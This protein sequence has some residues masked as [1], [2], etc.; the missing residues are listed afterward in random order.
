MK[1]EEIKR[2]HLSKEFYIEFRDMRRG[3]IRNLY[4]DEVERIEDQA[5][6]VL[7]FLALRCNRKVKGEDLIDF[8]WDKP[9]KE[10]SHPA[11]RIGELKIQIQNKINNV[12]RHEF[13]DCDICQKGNPSY[14]YLS[15]KRGEKGHLLS[16]DPEYIEYGGVGRQE[17]SFNEKLNDIFPC[18]NYIDRPEIMM[19]LKEAFENRADRRRF[20]FLSGVGGIGKSELARKFAQKSKGSM[21]RAVVELEYRETDKPFDDA[22]MRCDSQIIAEF[23]SIPKDKRQEAK[24][25]LLLSADESIL[26]LVHNFDQ[27]DFEFLNRLK[28]RTGSARILF[29]T[30]LGIDSGIEDYGQVVSFDS[31]LD[32]QIAFAVKV[33][34]EYAKI[35][36]PADNLVRSIVSHIGG[37]TMMA[38]ILGRQVKRYHGSLKKVLSELE[39][40]VR[41]AL[42][43]GGEVFIAKDYNPVLP[44]QEEATPYNILKVIFCDVLKR[45]FTER[46]R[47]I[48][49]AILIEGSNDIYKA[50]ACWLAEMVGDLKD[51]RRC[52]EAQSAIN[53]LLDMGFIQKDRDRLALHP[54]IA[55]LVTDPELSEDGTIIAELSIDFIFHLL[56]NR[57]V[58]EGEKSS[59][60]IK[61]I[62]TEVWRWLSHISTIR[63]Y[64]FTNTSPRNLGWYAFMRD[65]DGDIALEHFL[66]R[67]KGKQPT[68]GEREA[69]E[70]E[71]SFYFKKTTYILNAI[72]YNHSNLGDEHVITAKEV[73]DMFLKLFAPKRYGIYFVI[74]YTN[75]RSLWLYD[76]YE[77]KEWCLINCSEQLL[78]EFRYYQ[79]NVSRRPQ[80]GV[81]VSA[82][83]VGFVADHCP[84]L[85]FVPSHIFDVPVI[86]ILRMIVHH[87]SLEILCLPATIEHLPRF[88]LSYGISLKAC[89]FLGTTCQI[90][91]KSFYF[92]PGLNYVCLPSK[93]SYIDIAND[94]FSWCRKLKEFVVANGT[95]FVIDC[96]T[97]RLYT[98]TLNSLS[99]ENLQY[100]QIGENG[101]LLRY[102]MNDISAL[103]GSPSLASPNPNV[104]LDETKTTPLDWHKFASDYFRE[105]KRL[106]KGIPTTIDLE[107]GTDC[108]VGPTGESLVAAQSL[109]EKY[110]FWGEGVRIPSPFPPSCKIVVC[111]ESDRYANSGKRSDHEFPTGPS[112]IVRHCLAEAERMRSR[113]SYAVAKD[114]YHMLI[115]FLENRPELFT[116]R[117]FSERM[118]GVAIGFAGCYE[119]DLAWQ[120]IEQVDLSMDIDER[121]WCF[122]KGFIAGKRENLEEALKFKLKS[123]EIDIDRYNSAKQENNTEDK[124][125]CMLDLASDY[126]SL[127]ETYS[128]LGDFDCSEKYLKMGLEIRKTHL[129]LWAEPYYETTWP[130]AVSYENLGDMYFRRKTPDAILQAKEY[131]QSAQDIVVKIFE[132]RG[133]DAERIDNKI[134]QCNVKDYSK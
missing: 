47:Q 28:G 66:E 56:N 37:H 61:N 25:D 24:L 34:C 101:E 16:I 79:Q 40:S 18:S 78:P 89:I 77:K 4:D 121:L 105:Y 2:I 122:Y 64:W 12:L 104:V 94:S 71:S 107:I 99:N 60:F 92:C 90:G 84:S 130:L 114:Y 26:I 13:S 106:S 125:Y 36:C 46:E 95:R 128:I 76:Y 123:L 91:H 126:N 74:N 53:D 54:L 98:L 3:I 5:A 127:G 19:T 38:A 20:V 131:Y 110:P 14:L 132:T 42:K 15:K 1:I 83:M 31:F 118:M 58:S 43:V 33:F 80:N 10:V 39:L 9:D 11:A 108:F 57:F 23:S 21:F 100:T 120:A 93:A 119:Y 133:L 75:G 35:S 49:G 88:A 8:L 70:A 51:D 22:V 50:D 111:G 102:N 112:M 73:D 55:Q 82:A 134:A 97:S 115:A 48:F 29:T 52:C 96:P 68:Q 124:L 81:P 65:R 45:K 69:F 17:Y 27:L 7:Y 72:N 59:Y 87:K 32:S 6:E 30:R 116:E 63:D 129:K 117:V 86:T 85:L 113:G 103:F 67:T 62:K 44:T 109:K 41:E